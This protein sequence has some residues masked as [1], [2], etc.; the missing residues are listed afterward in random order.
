M[1]HVPIQLSLGTQGVGASPFAWPSYFYACGSP[2]REVSKNT[3][4]I[5]VHQQAGL[6]G[7]YIYGAEEPGA[8]LMR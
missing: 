6:H 2:Y 3:R 8:A 7:R 5:K 1:R 4:R